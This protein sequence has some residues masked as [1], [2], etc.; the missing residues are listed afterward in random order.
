[1][2]LTKA[3]RSMLNTGISD[4]SDATAL[5]FDS[6]ENATFAGHV[7][8]GDNKYLK[9]GASNDLL[10][11]HDGSSSYIIDNGTG[12][13]VVAGSAVYIKNAAY[14][15]QMIS[16]IQD[17]QV[18]LY[19]NN[20]LKLATANDG[21]DVTGKIDCTTFESTGAATVG[22]NLTVTGNLQVDGT[23]TT[24]NSTTYT[25]DD[26]NITLASGAGSSSAAD[27]AGI[28]IDGASATWNYTHSNTSWVANKNV[29]A[30]R[31]LTTSNS[32]SN[33]YS[34]LATRSGSGTSS[35]DIYGSSNTL[36]L[37][38]S[39]SAKA[40]SF[41]SSGADFAGTIT[42]AGTIASGGNI[43]A[44]SASSPTLE[45]K[46]TTNNV[47]F[48]AYA[49][50]SNAHLGTISNHSL[51]ID[52]NNTAA[53]SIDASQNTTISNH[54][55]VDGNTTLG[56][57]DTDTVTIPG[58]LAVDTDTLYVDVTNDRVGIN[59]GTSPSN[60]L[61]V[62]GVI[63]SGNFSAAGIGGTPGDANTAELGPGYLNLARDDTADAKQIIFGKNG[64]KHAYLETATAG[65]YIESIRDLQYRTTMTNS[66]AGHHIFKSYNTEI[67]RIDGANNRVGI[68]YDSPVMKLHVKGATGDVPSNDSNPPSNGIAIFDSGGGYSLVIGTDD[69]NTGSA[70]IQSQSA[71]VSSSEYDL[72]LNPN[73]GNVGIGST[74]PQTKF[75]VQNT[76]GASGIEFSMGASLN[77]I[78]SYDRSASDYVGLKLD[79]DEIRFGVD[80]GTEVVRIAKGTGTNVTTL[81]VGTNSDY[82]AGK[83]RVTTGSTS[84]GTAM[85][86]GSFQE[87][88]NVC[89]ANGS[90]ANNYWHIKTNFK[91]TN[92]I[93][94]VARMHGY[95]YGNGGA[96][97]DVQ[98]SGYAYAGSGGSI[99][100]STT[101]NNGTSSHTLECYKASD[102]YVCFR[103]YWVGG[104]YTGASFDIK[105][106]SPTGYNWNFQVVSQALN[107]TSG[108]HF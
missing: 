40:V 93:M 86:T 11:V 26:L 9:M 84:G 47:Q 42:S 58:P 72:L 35:P 59:T 32:S 10:L 107:T 78:Q 106:P 80:N 69:S 50:D 73:G 41:N 98:R 68:G 76:N 39:D 19:Y 74:N 52:T 15:E 12:N 53:I 31:F 94:F 97:I 6:S 25:V 14:N 8:L 108:N 54:L 60:A 95:A 77:Y 82:L 27:G 62:S 24:I 44:I 49:Q 3:S 88:R 67:M 20:A 7:I 91:C 75:V 23:T 104:Y 28:T 57:A 21:I 101:V 102:D 96:I 92:N 105:M 30:P 103:G 29:R 13:L 83:M 38:Y 79:G 45:I 90:G 89:T 16:A 65:M 56:N 66:T 34:I 64:V 87:F 1:M 22:G 51:I 99:I 85:N 55:I 18:E 43:T 100:N 36:V 81:K 71:N 37:G 17:A 2:A 33:F 46:D 63:T 4:S 5:T 70:W 48:K 61:S